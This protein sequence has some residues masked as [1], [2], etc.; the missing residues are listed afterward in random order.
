[1]NNI[2]QSQ[3]HELQLNRLAAQRQLYTDAKTVFVVRI[4]IAVPAVIVWS[5]A[6]MAFTELKVYAALWAIFATLIEILILS[7]K[8]DSLRKEAAKIQE[9][10]DCDVLLLK[11]QDIKVGRCPDPETITHYA[12]KYKKRD[13]HYSGLINWYPNA[14]GQLPV[15]LARIICQRSNCAWDSN[16]RRRYAG[17]LILLL[18]AMV[19]L[20]FVIGVAG[21][22]SL[23]KF[24]L[25]VVFPL[26]P[27]AVLLIRQSVTNVKIAARSD[28]IRTHIAD[29]WEE[30]IRGDIAPEM[31]ANE[32]RRLQDEIY[33][34]RTMCPVIFDWVYNKLR[35]ARDEEMNKTTEDLI[36]KA[37]S[38]GGRG[39]KSPRI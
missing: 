9:L 37:L 35:R 15:H 26:F 39:V 31:L 7:P 18:I 13:P 14:V 17:W 36:K 24:I 20:V 8:H 29:L 22:L 16:L 10:F 30:A 23:E 1:M 34:H 25:A 4:M 3:S 32:C 11:W 21:R 5:F 12:L 19:I 6:V 38:I 33:E 2:P 27:A 28:S